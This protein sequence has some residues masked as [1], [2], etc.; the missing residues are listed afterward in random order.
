MGS[1]KYCVTLVQL[2]AEKFCWHIGPRMA[3]IV[4]LFFKVMFQSEMLGTLG[5]DKL[6]GD[7]HNRGM[8]WKRLLQDHGTVAY[9]EK[10]DNDGQGTEKSSSELHTQWFQ[11]ASKAG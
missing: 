9:S 4:P 11:A 3:V 1:K 6:H 7:S 8:H 2:L 5:L 10:S